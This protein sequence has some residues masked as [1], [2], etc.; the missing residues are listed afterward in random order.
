VAV[1]LRPYLPHRRHKTSYLLLKISYLVYLFILFSFLYFLT[2]YPHSLEEY[3]TNTL[4]FTLLITLFVPSAAMLARKRIHRKRTFYNFFFTIL[5]FSIAVFY[6]L[7]WS[8]I[9][10]LYG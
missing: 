10:S 9:R 4:F 2:F 6:I 7:T 8:N 5:H 1:L 3:F